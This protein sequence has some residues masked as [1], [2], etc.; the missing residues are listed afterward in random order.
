MTKDDWIHGF[1]GAVTVCNRDGIILQM[2]EKAAKAF[3]KDGGK[4]LIGKNMF[5]CHPP[6]AQAKIRE[7]LTGGI[8]NSYTIEKHGVKKLIYQAPWYENGVQGGIVELSLEI[9]FEME[10]FVRE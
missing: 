5:D 8:T 2:N 1:S 4:A 7:L 6:K 10:H 3:E 9:P